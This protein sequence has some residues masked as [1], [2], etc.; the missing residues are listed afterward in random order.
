[1]TLT[2]VLFYTAYRCN[3]SLIS[4]SQITDTDFDLDFDHVLI[5]YTVKSCSV[6]TLDNDAKTR[7]KLGNS[8]VAT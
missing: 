7:N 2:S 8:K 6:L 5:E 4:S 1:M 3:T